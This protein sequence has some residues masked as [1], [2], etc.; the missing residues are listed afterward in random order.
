MHKKRKLQSLLVILIFVGISC[1]KQ[2]A[3][4]ASPKVHVVSPY[5]NMEYSY[6]S[7]AEIHLECTV[8]D[9]SPIESIQA[10]LKD[11]MGNLYYQ[12]SINPRVN[13]YPFHAHCTMSLPTANQRMQFHF[14]ATDNR[15][16][17]TDTSIGFIF[18][19]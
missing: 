1:K 3:D 15:G 11:S 17:K 16:N 18:K 10:E 12:K 4:V 14:I 7:D 19:P 2:T 13:I 6:T 5:A 9:E 8:S